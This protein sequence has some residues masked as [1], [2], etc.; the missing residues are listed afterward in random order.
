[1]S[2]LSQQVE[3]MAVMGACA[4]ERGRFARDLA[5]RRESVL[6]PAERIA[7]DAS[8]VESAL[9]LL[10]IVHPAPELVIEYPLATGATD[11][12]GSLTQRDDEAEGQTAR[13]RELFCVV[14]ASH[15]LDDLFRADYVVLE[16]D[17]RWTARG[18]LSYVCRAEIIVKQIEYASTVVL[19]NWSQLAREELL[20]LTAL[21]AHLSPRADVQCAGETPGSVAESWAHGDVPAA[22]YTGEETRAGWMCVLNGD[23]D[24]GREHD[25]V[26]AV[27]YEQLRPF[28]PGRLKDL[29]DQR[30]EAEEFGRVAR[31]AGFARL[32]TRSHITAQWDHVGQVISLTPATDDDDTG[33]TDELLAIGQELAF[34][35]VDL[36]P[37]GLTAALDAAAVTDAELHAGPTLWQEFADPFPGWESVSEN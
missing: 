21:V 37:I 16:A 9:G 13:L 14:D 28:H 36:D 10:G 32:A 6:L 22:G 24:P 15:L 25:R 3:V 17:Q 34:I 2:G 20:M 19:V 18:D 4:P 29:L 11:V 7:E 27:R 26:S 30:V 35:G 5:L 8:A 12:I 23:F 31:S 1:M 33:A